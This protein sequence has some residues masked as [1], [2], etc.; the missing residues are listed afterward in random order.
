MITGNYYCHGARVILHKQHTASTHLG[1]CPLLT[2]IVLKMRDVWSQCLNL[3]LSLKVILGRCQQNFY[4]QPP[5]N[6]KP[7]PTRKSVQYASYQIVLFRRFNFHIEFQPYYRPFVFIP[8]K[9]S[10]NLKFMDTIFQAMGMA[11]HVNPPPPTVLF[12][13]IFAG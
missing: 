6:I 11:F 3:N 8:I 5:V 13:K 2:A 1:N 9:M 10:I 7:F 4:R 12:H